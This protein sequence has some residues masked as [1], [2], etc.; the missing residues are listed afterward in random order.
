MTIKNNNK[1][2][3]SFSLFEVVGCSFILCLLS[4]LLLLKL[5]SK[6]IQLKNINIFCLFS[7]FFS[8]FNVGFEIASNCDIRLA[9]YTRGKDCNCLLWCWLCKRF[10][11][12]FLCDAKGNRT[13]KENFVIINEI[14]S[15]MDEY[16]HSI[17]HR[18]TIEGAKNGSK[19]L[20][21]WHLG[22]DFEKVSHNHSN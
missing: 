3:L 5:Q 22:V 19:I 21:W 20:Y 4:S 12:Q 18:R 15:N 8:L 2:M 10:V 6:K 17:M 11:Y 14:K 16:M 13:G 7:P 9:G 1:K